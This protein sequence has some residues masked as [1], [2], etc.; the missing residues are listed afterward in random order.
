MFTLRVSFPDAIRETE[1]VESPHTN[2]IT[3]VARRMSV[4]YSSCR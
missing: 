3:V 2:E 1:I 4:A